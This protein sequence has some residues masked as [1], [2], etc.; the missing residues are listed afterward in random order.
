M[1]PVRSFCLK[2]GRIIAES[3]GTKIVL[4][5][6]RRPRPRELRGTLRLSGWDPE[7]DSSVVSRPRPNVRGRGRRRARGRSVLAPLNPL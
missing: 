7:S 3:C 2:S 4:V 5:L 1:G 6:R